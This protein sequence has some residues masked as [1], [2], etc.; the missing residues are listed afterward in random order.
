MTIALGGRV[1]AAILKLG[2]SKQRHSQD[3]LRHLSLGDMLPQWFPGRRTWLSLSR[4]TT[5]AAT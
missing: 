4:S 5:P 1:Q 2:Q 3:H